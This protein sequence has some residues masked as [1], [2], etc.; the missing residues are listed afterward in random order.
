MN[1][2][3]SDGAWTCREK[4][5]NLD[6]LK[7]RVEPGIAEHGKQ[8]S[9]QPEQHSQLK[10]TLSASTAFTSSTKLRHSSWSSDIGV[11][12]ERYSCNCLMSLIP[13]L[14]VLIRSPGTVVGL[15]SRNISSYEEPS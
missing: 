9:P 10:T 14:Y 2:M 6:L 13:R 1:S 5:G 8:W 7:R 12:P 4:E 11:L 15:I 3:V